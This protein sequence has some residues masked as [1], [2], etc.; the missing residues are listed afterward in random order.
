[1]RCSNLIERLINFSSMTK[2]NI[3]LEDY[4]ELSSNKTGKRTIFCNLEELILQFFN[5]STIDEAEKFLTSNNEY[6][7]HCPFCKR[8]GHTKHKL[9]IKGDLS[10]GH[11]F[12]CTRNYI[13]VGKIDEIDKSVYLPKF[14][15]C[16]SNSCGNG[17]IITLPES[18]GIWNLDRYNYEFETSD[19]KGEKYLASRHIFLPEL[20]KILDF[21][22]WDGNV[23]MPFKYNNNVFY[24]QIRFTAP[25]SSIRYFFPPISAKPPYII[26]HGNNKKFIIVEGVFDAVAALIQAPEFTP[27]AV[28]GSSISDYQLGFL[29]SYVPE[30]I[31]VFMDETEISKRIANRVRSV[32][33]Y[34]QVRIIPSDGTDPEEV[35]I[36]KLRQGKEFRWIKSQIKKLW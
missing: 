8:E 28:L 16:F 6:I 5:V 36:N 17:E 34:S 25:G 19:E 26:E 14:D 31:I 32:I 10:V 33:P 7:I 12:V 35:L 13:N 18:S 23:V 15:W 27:F 11:C 4:R 24:Y 30:E 22:Y 9:Y 21:K 2:I 1:M 3:G 20:A 29:R